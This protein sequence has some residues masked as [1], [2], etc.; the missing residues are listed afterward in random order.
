M[1]MF[2]ILVIAFVGVATGARAQQSLNLDSK[3]GILNLS[4]VVVIPEN[5]TFSA[6]LRQ[7]ESSELILEL[8]SLTPSSNSFSYYDPNKKVLYLPTL[9]IGGETFQKVQFQLAVH[10]HQVL[11]G[12]QAR[13]ARK[14]PNLTLQHV[15]D[16][17]EKA[18]PSSAIKN[19]NY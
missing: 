17:K 8:D 5:S 14:R 2:L 7:V 11:P 12:A 1:K 4:E 6:T 3:R 18:Q 9:D 19:L 10:Q 13:E 16:L 15:Q